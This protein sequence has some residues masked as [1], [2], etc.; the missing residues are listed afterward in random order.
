MADAPLRERLVTAGSRRVEGVSMDHQ[1]SRLA[2]FLIAAA[3]T[4]S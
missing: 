1:L 4:A 2:A 3:R